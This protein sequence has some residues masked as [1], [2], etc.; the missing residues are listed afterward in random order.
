MPKTGGTSMNR[1]FRDRDFLNVHVD[2]DSTSSKHDSV[3]L[4][5][6]SANCFL[7]D[8][9]R[10]FTLRPLQD[11]LISD[12]LHKRRH[13]NLPQLDFKPVLSGLFYSL[14][15]GGVWVSADWWLSYFDINESCIPLRLD[16]LSVDLNSK[17]LPL[18]PPNT[19]PFDLIP[20]ENRKP[21]TYQF[22]IRFTDNDLHR[23]HSVNP[24]W[25]QLETRY[26]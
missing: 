1:L 21:S 7:S 10:F 22:P 16:R 26:F 23:I 14:R 11:W 2:D 3:A 8:R 4:R 15:L 17:L 6:I 9:T 13:M 5:E 18:L 25:S 24:R 19:A 20:S 12:W